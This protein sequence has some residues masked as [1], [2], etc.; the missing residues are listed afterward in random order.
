[1]SLETTLGALE[2]D[3]RGWMDRQT[4]QILGLRHE[5]D[6]L[7][8]KAVAPR[9]GSGLKSVAEEIWDNESFKSLRSTGRGRAY[10]KL[11]SLDSILMEHKATLTGAGVGS[12]VSGVLPI[13][14][15]PGIVGA[16]IRRPRLLDLVPRKPMTG[17][18]VDFIKVTSDTT[19][20]SPQS[21]EGDTKSEATINLGTVSRQARTFACW[22]PASRQI[23]DD[24]SELQ[25]AIRV[26]LVG[27]LLE[28]IEQQVIAGDGLSG[29]LSGLS[30]EAA[31]FDDSLLV[32]SDGW[33]HA[34]IVRRMAEQIE[35]ANEGPADTVILHPSTWSSIQL[36]KATDG[37]YIWSGTGAPGSGAAPRLWDLD[38]VVSTAISSGYGLV[39]RR[40]TVA[41]YDKM[42]VT[43]DLSTE[44]SDFFVRNLVALRVEW[45]GA[46]A[47]YRPNSWCYAQF[48]QSPA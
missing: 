23:L 42:D 45:R 1:M 20:A 7:A 3:L 21:S 33:E 12:S 15:E 16:A 25:N 5:L 41:L 30:T 46:F 39:G 26:H 43:F 4:D 44:H 36:A 2:K 27:R 34:D 31:A 10:I 38:V 47:C 28:E 35:T 22:I 8:Q 17:T 13:M 40:D 11:G 18:A 9:G 24:V 6:A 48:T 32:E 37:Q 29:N 14:R 19:L